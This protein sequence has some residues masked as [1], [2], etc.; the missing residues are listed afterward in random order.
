[1]KRKTAV[2]HRKLTD[3]VQRKEISVLKDAIPQM[4]Q[5]VLSIRLTPLQ[6]R[7]ARWYLGLAS[8]AL[9]GE[10]E[11]VEGE[12]GMNLFTV[13]VR[14]TTAEGESVWVGTCARLLFLPPS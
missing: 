8:D 6:R 4:T 10:E 2:L 13:Q 11:A 5:Y 14:A 9:V 3:M 7:L 1:M 12:I